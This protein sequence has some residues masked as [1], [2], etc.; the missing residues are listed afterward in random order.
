MSIPPT[1]NQKIFEIFI[2]ES[3]CSERMRKQT[4]LAVGKWCQPRMAKINLSQTFNIFLNGY[5]YIWVRRMPQSP[6][7]RRK[8]VCSSTCN[9][10][11]HVHTNTAAASEWHQT[12]SPP[13]RDLC[14]W[15]V[16]GKHWRRFAFHKKVFL[17]FHH[18]PVDEKTLCVCICVCAR[19]KYDG[20]MRIKFCINILFARQDD[21]FGDRDIRKHVD[22]EPGRIRTWLAG[23][24]SLSVHQQYQQQQYHASD[25]EKTCHDCVDRRTEPKKRMDGYRRFS[26]T[27]DDAVR[28]ISLYV[29]LDVCENA[30]FCTCDV[31]LWIYRGGW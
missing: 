17:T 16:G 31:V 3:M 25:R 22:D 13:F 5:M 24:V 15:G 27:Q 11:V 2:V 9:E 1:S 4:Q 7:L 20:E 23:D 18:Q 28:C 30:I 19:R 29:L 14:V 6:L 10:I 12:K 21:R 26:S 8:S